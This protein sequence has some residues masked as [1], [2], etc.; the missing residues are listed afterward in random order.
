[1]VTSNSDVATAEGLPA[2][3]IL[4]GTQCL[5]QLHYDD[6]PTNNRRNGS[7][8]SYMPAYHK[9]AEAVPGDFLHHDSTVTKLKSNY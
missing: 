5:Q 7:Y 6:R 3:H 8:S 1:M 9:L 2:I 4:F